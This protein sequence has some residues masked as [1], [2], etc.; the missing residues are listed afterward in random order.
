MSGSNSISPKKLLTIIVSVFL[1][2]LGFVVAINY[3]MNPMIYRSAYMVDMA[4]AMREGKNVAIYDPN[5]N[6][7]ALRRVQIENLKAPPEIVVSGGSR[8]QEASKDHVPGK[9]FFN[10]HGHS[11]YA[12]DFF[13]IVHLLEKNNK[14][15]DTLVLSL[16]YRIFEPIELRTHTGWREWVPEYRAM[17]KKLELEPTSRLI[18]SKSEHWWALFSLKNA[19]NSL[20]RSASVA[21]RPGP[22][23][24]AVL[25][26]LDVIGDD[27]SLRWSSQNQIRFS[28]A[29][30]EKDAQKRLD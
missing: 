18:T 22:T 14:M 27:G 4:E 24:S 8:W 15:P 29:Y 28:P 30:A 3:Y 20:K 10:A 25:E 23:G 13:A 19:W 6:W 9:V 12:E 17:Y 26:T 11:D 1:I 5:I 21:E 16:R 7:R 2:L